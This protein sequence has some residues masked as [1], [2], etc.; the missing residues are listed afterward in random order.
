[1]TGGRLNLKRAVEISESRSDPQI[2][3]ETIRIINDCYKLIMDLC[4]NTG[5]VSDAM[6]YV[7]QKQEQIDILNKLDER[8]PEAGAEEDEAT[9]NGVF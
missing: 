2:K 1:M 7:T 9:T 5:V 8:I 3:L 6:K 4:T